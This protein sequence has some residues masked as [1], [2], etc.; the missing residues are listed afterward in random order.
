MSIFV[1]FWKKSLCLRHRSLR[2]YLANQHF[3]LHN[4]GQTPVDGLSL[5]SYL[6]PSI[7]F[8]SLPILPVRH[9]EKSQAVLV[10]WAKLHSVDFSQPSFP[11]S[12]H[13][14]SATMSLSKAVNSFPYSYSCCFFPQPFLI[15]NSLCICQLLCKES[16]IVQWKKC[17]TELNCW[18]HCEQI[19][20]TEVHSHLLQSLI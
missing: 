16:P 8:Q 14:V 15:R 6:V 19:V 12:S 1:T 4:N 2:C 3:H 17:S 5:I 20:F 13:A 9:L 18:L 10:T 11:F 7:P